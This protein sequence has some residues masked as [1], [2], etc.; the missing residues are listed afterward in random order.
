MFPDNLTR[1]ETRA[2]AEL[3]GTHRYRIE[4][5]LSGRAVE[6]PERLFRSD[7]T[8]T[9]DARAAGDLHVDLIADHVEAASLDG[10]DLDPATFADSRLPLTVTPGP[11]TVR[12]VAHCRYSRTGEGLHRFVDPADKATYLYTQFEPADARRVF[13]NFEQPDLKA[14]FTIGVVAPEDWTV[15]SNGALLQVE[16]LGDGNARFSFAE[17]KPI[18]TYLTALVAGDYHRTDRTLHTP[19]GEVPAAL[20][21]RRSLA[22]HLDA[23]RIWDVTE[24]GFGVFER[25]F[26]QPYP[27]GK[28][29]QVFVPEYNGGAME[30]VGCVT[31]RD[32]YVFRSRATPASYQVRDDTILHE[33]SHMWF[34]DLVTMRWWDDL[35]LKESFATWASNFALSQIVE[36]PDAAWASFT[37]GFKTWAYR[38]DQL[39]STHPIAADMVDLEAVEQN[40]DGI[41]Y[42]K[43][44]SVLVQLVAY[45]GQEDFLAGCRQY[46]QRHAYGNTA[47][48]DLL[49]ALHSASGRDLSDWSAQWLETTG[50]NTLQPEITVDDEGTIT[51]FAVLQSAAPEHPTLRQHRIAL[52]LYGTDPDDGADSDGRLRRVARVEIDVAGERTEVTELVGLHRPPL[53]LV[54]D[55]DLSYAKVRLDPVSLATV[56]ARLADVDS[57]LARAVCWAAAWDMCR[58]G[59][60]AA[61][62]YVELVLSAVAVES[63]P[64]AVRTVLGQ[65]ASAARHYTPLEQRAEVLVRWQDGVTDLMDAADPGSDLQLALVKA[66]PNAAEDARGADRLAGWLAGDG[67]PGGVEI[68]P[69]LRW[70]AVV[71]LA[72]LGRLDEAAIDTE[73]DRDNTV[74]GAEQAAAAKAARPTAEAKAEAWR[75]AAEADDVPN[76]TQRAVTLA[77]WQRGQDEV[78]APYVEKYLAA[79]G[80]ISRGEGGWSTR[81]FALRENLLRFGFPVPEQLGP[82]IERLDAWLTDRT[83]V[84]SVRRPVVEGRDNAARSLRCQQAG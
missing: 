3:V 29:D 79:A 56:V 61:A 25:H 70:S 46:F 42:A 16:P 8:L 22:E 19:S 18:S 40:F 49:S 38:Q 48:T 59:E 43:G 62:Q 39:P 73:A 60:M 23:D 41:T 33:L 74:T 21:C 37:N 51:S 53:L 57:A 7:T 75:L 45:V 17:T 67:V 28:Y 4:V 64:V 32:E 83:L 44:A 82:F 47:L 36:D 35:W 54:N 66:F 69:E 1:A 30:N 11:H 65:A 26:A 27:F 20:Y 72:R 78:L 52:G 31:L 68:D 14:E 12:V 63:D 58:D 24:A 34:G 5:D 10:I 50:V 80:E 13:A 55:D 15:V 2:R 81:G 76:G 71:N 77:F 9:F 84:D 6:D